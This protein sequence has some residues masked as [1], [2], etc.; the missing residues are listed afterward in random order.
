MQRLASVLK[1]QPEEGG[2][3]L[4]VGMLFLCLQAG[5]GMGDNAASALFF[6]RFG[7]DF[8]PYMYVLLGAATFALTLGYAAGLGRIERNRFFQ[9]LTAGLVVVLLVERVAL[10]KPFPILY[11]ILWLT[12][13]CMGMII[14][15]FSWNVAGEVSDARQAKR[16]FPLFTSA[17]ILGSVIGNSL[18][19]LIAKSLGTENLLLFY[20]A[21][22]AASHF[23]IR[24]IGRTYFRPG[25]AAAAPSSLLADLRSGFDFVRGSSLMKLMA[26]AAV[27]FSIMF[28]AIAFPF[29]KV[30]AASFP[31]EAAV[32][33]FLGLFSSIT[34]AVT[35]LV[36]LLIANRIY[37]R[38]GIVNSVLLLPLVYAIGFAVFAGEYSLTG[39]II[40]RFSQLVVLS[41][42]ASAAYSALFNVVPSQKRGQV[43]AF[44]NG[45]P[46]QVGV[47]LSGVLL[48]LGNRVLNTSEILLMGLAVTAACGYLVWKMRAAYG[49]ALVDALRAGRLEVFSSEQAGFAG[50]QGDAGALNVVT[51]ALRDPKPSTRRLAAEILGRMQNTLAIADLRRGLTDQDAGVRAAILT[52]LGRLGAAAT[53]DEVIAALTDP[54][55]EVRL[56]A[57]NVLQQIDGALGPELLPRLEQL[58]ADESLEVRKQALILLVRLGQ[59]SVGLNELDR[60]LKAD[61]AALRSA[62]LEAFGS[63]AGYC[64]GTLDPAPVKAALRDPALMIRLAACRGLAGWKDASATEALAQALQDEQSAVRSAAATSLRERGP[65]AHESVLRVLESGDE[66]ARDAAL[67]GLTSGFEPTSIRLRE[68][69]RGEIVRLR[70]VRGQIAGLPSDGRA[71]ALLRA[72]LEQRFGRGQIRLVKIV[73]LIGHPSAM[74]WI[75]KRMLGSDPQTRAAALE[76]LETLGDKGLAREVISLLEEQPRGVPPVIALG[77]ILKNG[78]RWSRALSVRAA[79]ELGLKALRPQ[80]AQMQSDVDDL[81]RESAGEALAQLEEVKPVNTLKTVST[82]ERV[83]L[84]R[85]VPIFSELSPEDLGRVAEIA[86]EEWYPADTP[87]CHEGDEGNLMYIIVDGQLHVVRTVN[88]EPR[89]LAERGRGDFVGEMAIIESAPRSATLMTDGEVRVLAIDGETFKEILREHAEVSLA[90]LRSFSRRLRDMTG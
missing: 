27:L 43:L 79:Q 81:V 45:V 83:L 39:G 31:N 61:D 8:L 10:F 48:V 47:A 34:T 58:L 23:L 29:S 66:P 78:D 59:D 26:Y 1:V 20:A 14:G 35:F 85:E 88:G 6:L 55:A 72:S 5:Q 32:A 87:I 24:R 53:R 76:A 50:L 73:G 65:A 28:F 36:S 41:G 9:L 22:L 63:V 52:A 54:E 57:L 67:D 12:I 77:A 16:L 15:T 75:Q 80:L 68:F 90:M 2:L 40:A 21:L 11:P 69:A 86:R 38:M 7:V 33:G 89:V 17:E 74:E 49:Q 30:V 56:R 3:A 19:G 70:D 51:R 13:S 82:L 62:G 46:S 44:E 25:Q 18:T 84:L 71:T 4:L 60:W 42:I 37:T 64:E